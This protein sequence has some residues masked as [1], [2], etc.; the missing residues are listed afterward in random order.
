MRHAAPFKLG[1]REI[2][3]TSRCFYRR[4]YTAWCG[5]TERNK[6]SSIKNGRKKIFSDYLP[7]FKKQL[8]QTATIALVCSKN[9]NSCPRLVSPSV[10]KASILGSKKQ[11]DNYEEINKLCGTQT[12]GCA[13]FP[14]WCMMVGRCEPTWDLET[15]YHNSH[16]ICRSFPSW[17]A[18]SIC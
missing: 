6:M 16:S 1:Y 9:R 14:F 5:Q 10:E 3:T 15:L 12:V 8:V 17:C 4:I 7:S 11:W 18:G 2:A 13:V